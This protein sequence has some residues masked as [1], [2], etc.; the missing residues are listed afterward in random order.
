MKTIGP[1]GWLAG[2]AVFA[3]LA[4]VMP[5]AFLAFTLGIVGG[6]FC[7]LNLG[8]SMRARKQRGPA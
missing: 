6:G 7:A 1:R 2:F 8:E 5:D 4:T 3:L